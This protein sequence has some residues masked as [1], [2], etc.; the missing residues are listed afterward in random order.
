M[1]L[2]S[3][4]WLIGALC[5]GTTAAYATTYS[6]PQEYATIQG[7]IDASVAGDTVL[8]D[9]GLYVENI[10]LVGKDIVLTSEHGAALTVLQPADPAEP[11]ITIAYGESRDCIVQGFHVTGTSDAPGV[12]LEWVNPILR[13]CI[14]SNCHHS[15]EGGGILIDDGSPL[16]EHCQIRDNSSEQLGGGIGGDFGNNAEFAHCDI[17]QNHCDR[18]SGI[19]GY[20]GDNTTAVHHCVIRDNTGAG[21]EA[22]GIYVQGADAGTIENNTIIGNHIG[23]RAR[24]L[25]DGGYGVSNCIIAW[26]DSIPLVYEYDGPIYSTIW[27]N[28]V[29]W[30]GD[31]FQC[32]SADPQFVDSAANDYHLRETSPCID[33]GWPYGDFD[34]DGSRSDAG[35]FPWQYEQPIAK[36]MALD[37][38]GQVRVVSHTPEIYWSY[39]DSLPTTQQRFELEVSST[40]DSFTADQLATGEVMSGDTTYQYDGLPLIDGQAYLYRIRLYDGS[41]WGSWVYRRFRLNRNPVVPTLL[42]PAEGQAVSAT[43]VQLRVDTLPDIEQDTLWFDFEIYSAPSAAPENLF[44][45]AYNRRRTFASGFDSLTSGQQYWWRARA[46]DQY[47]YSAWSELRSFVARS[48]TVIRVPSEYPTIQEAILA[49]SSGDTVL[50]APGLYWSDGNRDLQFY[51]RAI[52]LKSSDG[53]EATIIHAGATETEHYRAL[54]L[55]SGM[56]DSVVVEG[57]TIR[58]CRADTGG[59]VAGRARLITF[60][61]CIFRD[62]QAEV[63]GVVAPVGGGL[64]VE[65]HDC[66]FVSNQAEWGGVISTGRLFKRCTFTS[67][68]ATWGGVGSVAG[69]TFDSCSFVQNSAEYGAV[70]YGG[71]PRVSYSLFTG[72]HGDYDFKEPSRGYVSHCTFY[73]DDAVFH[74]SIFGTDLSITD[75]VIVETSYAIGY[76]E[77]IMS[78]T[79]LWCPDPDVSHCVVM[80]SQPG[81]LSSDIGENGNVAADPLFCDSED[82][83]FHV[84]ASSPCVGAASDGGTIGAFG[85]GCVVGGGGEII[86]PHSYGLVQN[87][88]NPF[89]PTTTIEFSLPR[90]AHVNLTVFNILGQRVRTLVDGDRPAGSHA[91]RWDG[92]SDDGTRVSS[93]VYFYRIDAGDW[94]S[95]RKMLLLK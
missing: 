74:L 45:S 88:P 57:F 40:T 46:F 92:T 31:G 6:V 29:P 20:F 8:V 75:C 53:P 47:E 39:H 72:N 81:C 22:A 68:S 73:R 1:R 79:G 21:P 76:C 94:T 5:S 54:W 85:V 42:S 84:A 59:A 27:G 71:S 56:D 41:Q 63:G 48:N 35:A 64:T 30:D 44:D 33:I 4:L 23:I 3:A 7:A 86:L 80:N 15:G 16:I 58:N 10:D 95:S 2:C 9:S 70:F 26:Q 43:G 66:E 24:T 91:V 38:R 13:E 90:S 36:R 65:F 25:R 78:H 18:G 77:C 52:V 32:I 49:A 89:N 50:V 87:Y 12:F 55:P 82:N 34:P 19:G 14:I 17:Y 51:E 60:K 83:N 37:E 62:N 67:N 61:D 69:G 93:G 28:G 11:V